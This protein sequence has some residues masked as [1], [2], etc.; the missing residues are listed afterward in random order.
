[1]IVDIFIPCFVDQFFPDTGFNMV[2]LL[3]KA[4]C[5]VNYNTEQTCCGQVAYNAGYWDECKEV[6]EKFIKEFPSDRYIV[7]PSASCVGMI[8]NHYPE[9]F[10][11]TALHN[12]YKQVQRNI[13]EF[14]YFV[15]NV[16]KYTNFNSSFKAKIT[17]LDTC[18]ALRECG[19]K[20]E[21]RTLLKNVQGLEIIE[22]E[23]SDT[24][25]GFGGIFA[26]KHEPVSIEMAKLK[27]EKA[28]ATG[29]EY[30]VSGDLSCLMHL[31]G[32][33]QKNKIPI[34]TMHICD[35][36]AQGL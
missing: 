9:I 16:L 13:N 35:V 19:I 3:K 31:E 33:I 36:L 11:N 21:P 20:D 17:Y 29:A 24:C 8:E 26:I 28:L 12:E 14:T 6:G 34:R 32:Y 4:G 30:I 22:M 18:C 27:V 5:S 15:V 1:M 7:S 10:F 25:C 2:K 23:D